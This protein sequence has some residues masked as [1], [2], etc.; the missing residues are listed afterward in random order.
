MLRGEVVGMAARRGGGSAEDPDREGVEEQQRFRRLGGSAREI[1]GEVV[2]PGDAGLIGDERPLPVMA[3]EQV[4]LR[5]ALRLA[6][7]RMERLRREMERV[8]LPLSEFPEMQATLD[9]QGRPAVWIGDVGSEGVL[10]LL[11][12]LDGLPR[13]QRQE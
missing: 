11:A 10:A 13:V 4:A 5:Q 12:L 8:G 1:S 2:Y 3:G 9:V 6:S 7:A